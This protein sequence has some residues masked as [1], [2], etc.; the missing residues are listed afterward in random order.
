VPEPDL[1][2]DLEHRHIG[3]LGM[4]FVRSLL[5]SVAYKRSNGW[6]VLTLEKRLPEGMKAE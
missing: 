3:G 5:D 6:N 2:A 4:H 1:S